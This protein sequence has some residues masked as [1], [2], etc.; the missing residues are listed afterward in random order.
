MD[1][2]LDLNFGNIECDHKGRRKYNV[3]VSQGIQLTSTGPVN[4]K[5]ARKELLKAVNEA[6]TRCIDHLNRAEK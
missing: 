4:Y 1:I 3:M 5:G 2:W 6:F